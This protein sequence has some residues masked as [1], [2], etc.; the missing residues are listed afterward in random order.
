MN[1]GGQKKI[2]QMITDQIVEKIQAV[3][4]GKEK[5][6]PWQKD[7]IG[8]KPPQNPETKNIYKGWNTF[9]LNWIA[10]SMGYN[11]PYWLSKKAFINKKAKLDYKEYK[12]SSIV[13]AWIKSSYKI[14]ED[15]EEKTI[16]TGKEYYIYWQVWNS[17]Q[18]L[19][20]EGT[21]GNIALPKIDIDYLHETITPQKDA[22]LI[23]EDY[24]ASNRHHLKNKNPLQVEHIG[25]KACY[26]P[27]QHI[28]KM[29]PIKQF[30]VDWNYPM[31]FFHELVHSTGHNDLIK[32]NLQ[33]G[34]GTGDYSF[35]ELVAEI[36]AVFLGNQC[37]LPFKFE[38][39]ISYIDGWLKKLKSNP[40]WIIKAG[41]K[42]Q[43]AS[44]YI[45]GETNGK[46]M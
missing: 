30:T 26:N 21:L 41:S 8:G 17:D 7:W 27:S 3:K 39:S 25:N 22:M 11:S 10:D 31:T 9:N 1:N 46:N 12:K 28:L 24:L 29:P 20:G 34:F 40:N 16:Y 44:D 19:K 38:N 45:L 43:Y 33:N 42:A 6:L 35:E 2:N 37:N 4:E 13:T 14:E 36:G 18:F 15:G 32:R 23:I 5:L